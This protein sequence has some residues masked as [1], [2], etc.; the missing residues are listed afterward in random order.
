[1]KENFFFDNYF[2]AFRNIL[3]F[4]KNT[5]KNLTLAKKKLEYL[6][7]NNRK[8]II[9]GNGGSAS[10]ASHFS[11]DLTK[12]SN[13]R[14]MNFNEA[15][16]ITCFANDYGYENWISKAIEFYGDRNDILILISSSGMSKN[17]LNACHSARKKNFSCIITF[18]VFKNTNKLK[19]KGDINFWIDSSKY[20]YVENAHQV[21]L[22]S[23]VDSLQTK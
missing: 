19:K 17:I 18:S 2:L 1:M 12:I 13:I 21:L 15:N 11:T 14:C 20:N 22:L 9:F 4:S 7:K 10:I 5:I 3:L 16:L 23:L 8:V 6:K